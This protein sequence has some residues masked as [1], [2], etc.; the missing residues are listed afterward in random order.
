[1]PNTL[2]RRHAGGRAGVLLTFDDGP[3]PEHTPAV[4]DRL[5]A[6][7]AAALFFVVGDRVRRSPHLV[8]RAV[9]EGHSVGNHTDTHPRLPALAARAAWREVGRCQR[10]VA[11]AAGVRP[12]WL[13]PPLGRLAPCLLAA[14]WGHRLRVATW[15]L[16]SGDWACRAGEDAD[17]CAAAVLAAVRPRD[18]VLLHEHPFIGRL[19]D[20][21]LPG[22]AGRGLLPRSATPPDAP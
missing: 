6:H 20:A 3:H 21:L 11:E 8:A 10:A 1:V 15:S 2:V 7:G 5:R 9:A 16:D 4:L 18:V 12:R 17:R 22:L 19:L 14:A 13:R